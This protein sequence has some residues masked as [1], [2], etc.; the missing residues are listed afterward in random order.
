[1]VVPGAMLI[2]LLVS[3]G[4][5][6]RFWAWADITI[7]LWLFQFIMLV[8][9]DLLGPDLHFTNLTYRFPM[10][11]ILQDPAL[12]EGGRTFL[13]ANLM[14]LTLEEIP[15]AGR[16]VQ[17]SEIRFFRPVLRFRWLDD[18]S[19]IGLN[20][21]FIKSL[22]GE[23]YS[24]SMSTDPSDFL[25][26]RVIQIVKGSLQF[27][28]SDA[29][30]MH[31]DDIS[32][33]FDA[34]PREGYPGLYR[35]DSSVK[36]PP[37]LDMTLQGA[38]NIDTGNVRVE[39]F[40]VSLMVDPTRAESLPDDIQGLVDR[41]RL[42]GNL[43]MRANGEVPLVD[44]TAGG[45]SLD[46]ELQLENSSSLVYGYTIP[47]PK[48]LADITLRE[49][50]VELEHLVFH[51]PRGGHATMTGDLDLKGAKKFD[52]QFDVVD[53]HIEGL[54]EQFKTDHPRYTGLIGL[55]GQ[56]SSDAQDVME[57]LKG[58]GSIHL[59]NGDILN[60]PVV[61]GL[62]EAVLGKEEW[63]LGNDVGSLTFHLEPNRVLFDDVNLEGD[64]LG[65]RGEGELY[66]NK[67][68]NFRFN[69]GPLEKVQM[70]LGGIGD[71]FG[72]L[73]DRLVT[74]QVTGTWEDP[75]FAGRV[76]GLGTRSRSTGP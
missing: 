35:L 63:P 15:V 6:V 18:G 8:S 2:G 60:V 23:E 66:F 11:V 40:F 17:I 68:I 53:L 48:M 7:R 57:H 12:S 65:V 26:I 42:V 50:Q 14:R 70:N 74:Y 36:R 51:L 67:D 21:G 46:V 58:A 9:G 62:Q 41:Y 1:M 33:Q 5:V 73:T 47:I 13:S 31:L 29:D 37:V 43:A 22:E 4:M 38:I 52:V 45:A 24:D 3:V 71:V 55:T 10:T 56:V 28:P 34:T 20:R 54:L 49:K 59:S 27:E 64:H 76:L 72:F 32:L 69:A 44:W 25:A 61:K 16:A 39:N 19:L 30:S 75:R